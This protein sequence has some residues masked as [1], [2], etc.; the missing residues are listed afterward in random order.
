LKSVGGYDLKC[1]WSGHQLG[2]YTST[3]TLE[4]RVPTLDA[5]LFKATI[6]QTL[7]AKQLKTLR[8]SFAAGLDF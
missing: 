5:R 6:S 3:N 7:S 1:L 4:T 8:E 2:H